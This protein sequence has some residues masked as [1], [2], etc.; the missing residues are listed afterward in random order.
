M[1]NS[2]KTTTALLASLALVV[3]SVL[4]AQQNGAVS[5]TEQAATD[6]TE[7]VDCPEGVEPPC[8][9]AEAATD[10]A[11]K[12]TKEERKAAK[13]DERANEKDA[14]KEAAKAA[15]QAEKAAD[16]ATKTQ[17]P[18]EADAPV[19]P[20]SSAD[21]PAANV[22]EPTADK[23][24]PAAEAM[25]DD[26]IKKKL[27][28]NDAPEAKAADQ[29]QSSSDAKAE[30]AEAKADKKAEEKAAAQAEKDKDAEKAARQAEKKADKKAERAEANDEAVDT[31]AKPKRRPKDDV[32]EVV[33]APAAAASA[34]EGS[35]DAEVTN[36]TLTEENSRSSDEDFEGKIEA[37]AGAAPAKDN[38]L[39]NLEKAL[40]LG[41]GALVVGAVIKGN[42]E[43]VST[44][45]DRLVVTN[46]DGGMEVIKDD[47]ALLRRPG[48]N[49][50]TQTFSDGSTRTVTTRED[51]TS[52]VTIRDADLRVL[53]RALVRADGTQVLLI[54]DTVTFEPVDVTTL[55][56]AAAPVAQTN[57][58]EE[59]RAALERDGVYDRRFSLGQIRQ[60]S[61]VRKLAPSIEVDTITFETGSAA[62]RPTE[63]EKLGDLGRQIAAMID[64]NPN[65]IF[66]VEGHTDA[67]GAA[68]TNL[69]LSDRRAESLALALTEYFGVPPE[70]LVVQGYG[71]SDL[72]VEVDSAER[73]N[74]RAG[75]R[76]ITGLMQVA[77]LN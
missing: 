47:N 27:G 77:S 7:A 37:T 21:A 73:A 56:A 20:R 42:R 33:P 69:I 65:E 49:V 5:S 67:V 11:A 15:K 63:A 32:V 31:S 25:T 74:R 59:L 38:G 34:E 41:A 4:P 2:L 52:V 26:A 28:A 6:L 54:D 46:K 10:D 24:A 48:S 13:K 44:S 43:V 22:V 39:S 19:E 14:E 68:G 30:K 12:M 3:P 62:I 66:L 71:E 29:A 16:K 40:L 76:R 18:A 75:L 51:G 58:A 36:E 35:T 17:A 70:N 23:A 50:E 9:E 57:N 64:R 53:R 8:G 55:P 60:I 45:Q 61:E 72:K 1:R